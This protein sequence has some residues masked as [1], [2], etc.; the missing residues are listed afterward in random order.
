MVLC[1]RS[2]AMR[3]LYMQWLENKSGWKNT[4]FSSENLDIC[5]LKILVTISP[6]FISV[7]WKTLR[8]WADRWSA[9]SAP[10]LNSARS[11]RRKKGEKTGQQNM[12][13]SYTVEKCLW[14]FLPFFFLSSNITCQIIWRNSFRNLCWL[15][16]AEFNEDV[17]GV[18]KLHHKASG[19]SLASLAENIIT[20]KQLPEMVNNFQAQNWK[21]YYGL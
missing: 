21:E 10:A 19:S 4:V 14:F 17:T 18:L 13:L 11:D 1:L 12:Y 20:A 5:F 7:L 3:S 6:V 8:E 16:V 2:H 15:C 9:Q